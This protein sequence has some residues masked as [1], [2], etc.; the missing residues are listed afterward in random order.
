MFAYL[1]RWGWQVGVTGASLFSL[2]Y[3]YTFSNSLQRE[4]FCILPL[5]LSLVAAFR[6]SSWP[7]W[8]RAFIVGLLHGAVVTIKPP[9]ALAFPVVLAGLVAAGGV[10]PGSPWRRGLGSAAGWIAPA[11]FGFAFVPGLCASYLLS[12]GAWDAFREMT[13]EYWPLYAQLRG[14]GTLRVNPFEL[15]RLADL[16]HALRRFAFLP[17]SAIGLYLGV[18]R[19]WRRGSGDRVELTVM[20]ALLAV[21]V[22]YIY[23]SG[24]FWLYH[25]LP[26]AFLYSLLAALALVSAKTQQSLGSAAFRS[27]ALVFLLLITWRLPVVYG[28]PDPRGSDVESAA[29]ILTERLEPGDTVQ[30]L[31]VT[32]GAAHA[33]LI[34]GAR[35]A[36][37]F[38]YDFH[39]YHHPHTAIIARLRQRFMRAMKTAQPRFVLSNSGFLWRPRGPGTAQHFP[40]LEALLSKRYGVIWRGQRLVLYELRATR[41]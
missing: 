31:D 9:L 26:L 24:K 14:E 20:L 34:S 12:H 38:L 6:L 32:G 39:F 1:R 10:R 17:I 30:P 21:S 28:Q 2:H 3:L 33:M 15:R 11:L 25:V 40:E 18:P 13:Q 22:G 27:A 29:E 8:L 36:T 5:A 23:V 16:G 41:P 37:P 19:I 35:L 7:L 4:Y